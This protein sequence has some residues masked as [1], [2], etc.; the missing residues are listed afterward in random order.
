MGN[1]LHLLVY[2]SIPDG[3]LLG[4]LGVF[5]LF[6]I[7]ALIKIKQV[8]TRRRMRNPPSAFELTEI[9]PHRP[10]IS[11]PIPIS[12]GSSSSGLTWDTYE[13]V[14]STSTFLPSEAYATVYL[15]QDLPTPPAS[16]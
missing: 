16:D 6:T 7:P 10:Y 13:A 1:I 2:F 14:P 9:N 12:A 15:D 5:L 8:Y 3:I 11:N 4:V